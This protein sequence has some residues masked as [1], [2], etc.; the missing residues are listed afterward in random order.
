MNLVKKI[1]HLAGMCTYTGVYLSGRLLYLRSHGEGRYICGTS[2]GPPV[3]RIPITL[4]GGLA[5]PKEDLRTW[6]RTQCVF[7]TKFVQ[8]YDI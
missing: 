4:E 7:L 6:S 3:W 1:A 2:K 5:G 8:V